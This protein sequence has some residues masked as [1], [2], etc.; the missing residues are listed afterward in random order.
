MTLLKVIFFLIVLN[1]VSITAYGQNKWKIASTFPSNLVIIGELGV[2]ITEKINNNSNNSLYLKYFEPGALV[3]PLEIFDA[4]SSGAVDAGWSTPGYWAG[5]IPALQIFSS[6]PFHYNIDDHNEW[7]WNQGGFQKMNKI[8]NKYNIQSIPC[9]LVTSEG[10]GW[11]K[12]KITNIE[13][14]QGLK[15]RFFG[16]GAKVMDKVGA[17]TM[18]LAGGDIYPALELGTIDATEFAPPYID[19][20]LGFYQVA[21]Y[22]YYPS[23]HQPFALL[24]LMI[25]LDSWNSISLD[26]QLLIVS[27]CKNNINF[28]LVKQE[29]LI[30]E[31]LKKIESKGV[32]INVTPKSIMP[33]LKSAWEEILIHERRNNEEFNSVYMAWLNRKKEKHITAKD[34]VYQQYVSLNK[35][36]KIIEKNVNM[37]K[38]K[39][40]T[41]NIDF[42]VP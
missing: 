40:N 16:L 38:T 24:E 11:F 7:I 6:L 42:A 36:K 3:P 41:P 33:Y 39:K 12:N 22:Y 23:W 35:D 17:N 34:Y 15:M 1:L 4:V 29:S 28:G 31:A 10:F 21:K 25:N 2:R 14:L 5:K 19:I 27:E 20:E 8:Y 30:P 37:I 32:I 9:G 13:D 26:Q 18:L